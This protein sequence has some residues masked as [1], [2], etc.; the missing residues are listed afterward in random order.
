MGE[1]FLTVGKMSEENVQTF[2]REMDSF[3]CDFS[4][5]KE[6]TL[7]IML[8]SQLDA[9]VY[10]LELTKEQKR[11]HEELNFFMSMEEIYEYIKEN[12]LGG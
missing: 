9:S 12:S 1:S 4:L 2:A 3:Y 11:S 10:E 8:A 7:K 6:D 5:T